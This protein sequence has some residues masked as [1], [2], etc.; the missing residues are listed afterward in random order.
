MAIQTHTP[1][2][3]R[4]YHAKTY[5]RLIGTPGFSEEMLRA[6]FKLYEGYVTHTNQALQLLAT[7]TLDPYAA[8]EVRRRLGW[9]WNGM[10][11]HELYFDGMVSGGQ[12]LGRESQLR[13]AVTAQWTS[14]EQWWKRFQGV[15]GAR[16]IGWAVLYYDPTGNHLVNAWVTEHDGGHL[17]GCAPIVVLDLFEHAY[18]RDYGL[19]R[20]P[21][22]EAYAQAI[23]WNACAVRFRDARRPPTAAGAAA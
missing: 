9:E 16:G 8:G 3:P 11:L 6:H 10:R 5:E 1:P 12:E 14:F 20:G 19:D 17:A 4:E 13:K 2:A 23:D 7:G 22:L 21:Y 15:A 18:M